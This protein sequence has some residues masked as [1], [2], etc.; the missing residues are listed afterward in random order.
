MGSHTLLTPLSSFSFVWQQA[1][2]IL[3]AAGSVRARAARS[4][5]A[6]LASHAACGLPQALYNRVREKRVLELRLD[7]EPTALLVLLGPPSCGKT[8]APAPVAAR[9]LVFL[10]HS[11]ASALLKELLRERTREPR[12]FYVDCRARDY[13]SPG[14]FTENVLEC[15]RNAWPVEFVAFLEFF[16]VKVPDAAEVLRV[17]VK[18]SVASPRNWGGPPTAGVEFSAGGA[19]AASS[20]QEF[21]DAFQVLAREAKEARTAGEPWPVI[22]IDEA[23]ALMDW[24]D[25]KSLKS[26]L[27]FFVRVTKQEQLAHVVLATSDTFFLQWLEKSA[28]LR[29]REC[30]RAPDAESPTGGV[31]KAFREVAVVGNLSEAEAREFFFQHV[32]PSL[33]PQHACGEAEWRQV[34]E[35]RA[36]W[37]VFWLLSHRSTCRCAAATLARCKLVL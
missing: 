24:E 7:K 15:I 2:T 20:L 14:A 3:A 35:V 16:G 23:N 8:G 12:P 25:K 37:A 11:L 5:T 27:A 31:N 22:I 36:Q 21:F 26:L 4:C 19:A 13:M 17:P 33:T 29:A 18:F 6:R 10:S 9:F 34:Y 28:S 32:L 30:Q 1:A